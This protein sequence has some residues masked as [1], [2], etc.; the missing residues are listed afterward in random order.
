MK[1]IKFDLNYNFLSIDDSILE[2]EIYNRPWGFYKTTF[3]NPYSQSKIIK[4]NPLGELS[5]Q[6]HKHRE[7][8]WIVIY[9]IGDVILGESKKKVSTGS[10]IFIPK[11]CKHKISNPSETK[12]LMIAEV[13][14]GEYFGEN[15]I[16]RYQDIYGR[17]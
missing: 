8:H 1:D 13:Q 15:D 7:E 2:N 10:Y 3:S 12:S 16:I 14:L 9:D 11:G 5:L 6:E 17:V 4:I